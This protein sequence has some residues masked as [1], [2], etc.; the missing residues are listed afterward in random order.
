MGMFTIQLRGRSGGINLAQM[1]FYGTQIGHL[2][3][4]LIS[5]LGMCQRSVA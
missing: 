5:I 2:K 1:E 4:E 3:G